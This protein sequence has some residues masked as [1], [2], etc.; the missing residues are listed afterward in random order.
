VTAIA[1]I[2]Y[3]KVGGALLR[4]WAAAGHEVIIGARDPAKSEARAVADEAGARLTTAEE[5]ADAAEVIVLALPGAAM[6]GTIAQLG[7]R[8]SGKVVID[9]T[10]H[11]GGPEMNS[12]GAIQRTAPDALPVRA[13]NSL[14]WENFAN[15][16]FDGVAAD[17]LW[18]GADSPI[19]EQLIADVG[20]RPLRVGDLDELAVVDSLTALWFALAVRGGRGR[21]LAWRV[22]SD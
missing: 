14:G 5:A 16:V 11:M 9:T 3:G 7:S 20:F 19:V 2:G 1:V 13:F 4:K 6:E 12:I 10:N 15:P 8:L 21:H 18:C 17:M 22:L